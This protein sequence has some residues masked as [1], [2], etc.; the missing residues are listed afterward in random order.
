LLAFHPWNLG[1][2]YKFDHWEKRVP[3]RPDVLYYLL[4]PHR[5]AERE[6][7]RKLFGLLQA[8]VLLEI[9][10]EGD[11]PLFPPRQSGGRR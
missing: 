9:L 4:R 5:W 10:Q 8:G 3:A 6:K 7:H 2:E 11:C 1:E